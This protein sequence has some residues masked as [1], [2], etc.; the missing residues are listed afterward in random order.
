MTRPRAKNEPSTY[1]PRQF[2]PPAIAERVLVVRAI[3]GDRMTI[4]AAAERLGIARVNMQSLAHRAES[5]I[6][7]A[8][9]PKSSGPPPKSARERELEQ[10]VKK[11]ERE[12][13]RLE[14]QLQA[15]DDMMGAAGEII[16]SLRGLPPMRSSQSS[17]P[18]SPRTSTPKPQATSDDPEPEP[19][20]TSDP[21]TR[22]LARIATMREQGPRAARALGMSLSTLRRQLGRLALGQP[23][24]RRRGG[25]RAVIAPSADRA[26]REHVRALGGL[27]GAASL[28]R[29]IAGVSR[30]AAA[31]IKCEE[32]TIIERERKAQCNHVLVTRPGAIRSFDAMH[33]HRGYALF[34]A[35]AYVC[36]RTTGDLVPVYDAVHVAA[37]L[38]RDF[39][40]HGAPLVLRLDRASC[41]GAEP[42]AS[43]L[44][45]FGVL[46]LH[47]PAH[48][49]QYYGDLERQNR[50]HRF[51]LNQDNASDPRLDVMITAL[52]CLWRR[53]SLNWQTAHE[54][55]MNRPPLDD[56]RTEFHDEV[57]SRAARLR[58]EGLAPDL[59]MRLAIE[60]ALIKKGYLRIVTS[61]RVL[62]EQQLS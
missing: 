59:A 53:P 15:A 14:E 27:V 10:Q 45:A 30:R 43:V 21:A 51:W 8:M 29:T 57:F 55:W 20:P 58:C 3:L 36:F 22:A 19:E 33:L 39:E 5:S 56:D 54:V 23:L 48:H 61:R 60:Q 32:L 13:A 62:C 24:R 17:S 1:H 12:K 6:I 7:E 49:P 28:A 47:G 9:T 35:D 50:E 11:L 46:P 42:V 44:R 26:V 40:R 16:R 2:V 41:H 4:S 25:A 34:A 18:R 52:N 31:D 38:A 37:S